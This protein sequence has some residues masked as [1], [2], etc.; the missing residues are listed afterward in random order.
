MGEAADLFLMRGEQGPNL[1][2]CRQGRGIPTTW[3]LDPS[4]RLAKTDMGQNSGA[5]P[6]FGGDGPP[7]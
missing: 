5:V 6:F 1:T 7:I 2:Q 4:S 3:H